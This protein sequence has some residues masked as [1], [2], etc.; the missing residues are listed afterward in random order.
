MS[1]FKNLFGKKEG[2]C[3]HVRIQEIN[4]IDPKAQESSEESCC[5][6]PKEKMTTGQ[7]NTKGSCCK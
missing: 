5:S 6:N 2:S 3:C 7:A 4:Q 1:I